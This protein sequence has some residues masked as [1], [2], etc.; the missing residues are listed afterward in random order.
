VDERP[1]S[2]IIEDIVIAVHRRHLDVSEVLEVA[3]H[4]YV[5]ATRLDWIGE[6]ATDIETLTRRLPQGWER[7]F[8]ETSARARRFARSGDTVGAA[9]A[10]RDIVRE[11]AINSSWRPLMFFK[12]SDVTNL[13]FLQNS[14]LDSSRLDELHPQLSGEEMDEALGHALRIRDRLNT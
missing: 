10:I 6:V 5:L 1:F 11:I 8:W 14:L 3:E 4:I 12:Y 9:R 7:R 2:Q 13:K